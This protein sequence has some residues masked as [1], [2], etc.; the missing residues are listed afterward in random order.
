MV[1]LKRILVFLS[2]VFA[3]VFLFGSY[4]YAQENSANKD[5]VVEN[6]VKENIAKENSVYDASDE[7]GSENESIQLDAPDEKQRVQDNQAISQEAKD[8]PE[9][10]VQERYDSVEK[11]I[12]EKNEGNNSKYYN[13]G[14]FLVD[15]TTALLFV[16]SN[17][18]ANIAGV[19]FAVW[20][21]NGSDMRG[22]STS[23]QSD[24][25]WM[26]FMSV[27][28]YCKSGSYYCLATVRFKDGHSQTLNLIS[29]DVASPS[30]GSVTTENINSNA[31]TYM[32]VVSV[33]N[34]YGI[35]CN[36]GTIFYKL[37]HPNSQFCA[38]PIND[39]S[40]VTLGAWDL[41]Y[42]KHIAGIQ[43]FVWNSG[44]DMRCYFSNARQSDGSYNY[45]FS[46][47]DF[48]KMGTFYVLPRIVRDN[49]TTEDLGLTSF[50]I[51]SLNN[52][53]SIMGSSG[54]TVDQMVR[55]Y[56]NH[57]QYPLYYVAYSD[58]KSINEMCQ[59]YYD[60]CAK[61]GVRAEV[62]FCQAMLET[63]YLQFGGAVDIAA[64][65]FAGIGA[66]DSSPGSYNWFPDVR[67][68]VRAQVQHLK[69]YASTLPLNQECVDPRCH[70]V[71]RGSALYVE[72]LGNGKWASST[73]YGYNIRG[74]IN[75][76]FSS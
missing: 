63:G 72:S 12:V 40:D 11:Q 64:Y 8:E 13:P 1:R 39:Q 57:A 71:N 20:T 59:I 45:A 70:L 42:A 22:Y 7:R 66:V 62:A 69:A 65:N 4:S 44:N 43:F 15:N 51:T 25:R 68:G 3:S 55:Y 53:Y 2:I 58:A 48:G 26:A 56:N 38:I 33:V 50:T 23:L 76:L 41:P 74:M 35:E 32:I 16:S 28:D 18:N 21:G 49:W 67:T 61:E 19:D 17:D 9:N 46:M 14:S 47:N 5:Y 30:I 37:D 10:I 34:G 6:N 31:G 27:R 75:T 60:E 73:T 52:N 54:T 36:V 29:F 24:G